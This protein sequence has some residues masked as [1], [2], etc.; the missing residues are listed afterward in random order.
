MNKFLTSALTFVILLCMAACTTQK[1]PDED[2]KSRVQLTDDIMQ[3]YQVD[4]DWWRIYN[5]KQLNQLVELA[6]KNNIDLAKSAIAVNKAL[7]QAN[8]LGENLV[9]T[10]SGGTRNAISQNI[11]DGGHSQPTHSGNLGVSYEVD[12]WQRLA[13]SVTAQQWEFAATI[14]DRESARLA[15]INSVVDAYYNLI[16]LHHAILVTE[17]SISNYE[18]IDELTS[19]K[20]QY[21][22]VDSLDP[23]QAKQAILNATSSLYDFQNQ[24]KVAEQT[25]RDLLNLK[26]NES[27]LI[28]YPDLLTLSLPEVDLNVPLSVIANRPDLRG[29]EYRLQS[30]FYD[31]SA[32]KKSW[33][34]TITL[35]G[36]IDS[37]S[38][39]VRKTFDM[40][41]ASGSLAIDLPFLQWNKIR[42][43]IKISKEDYEGVKLDLE[44]GITTALN[45]INTYYYNYAKTQDI[46]TNIQQKYNYDVQ[47]TQYY[48][49][50]YE[51]G[52]GELKDWLDA[53]NTET[54]SRISLLSSRH[55]L[56]QYENLIYKAIAGRYVTTDKA[57]R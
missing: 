45:E 29:A 9:P 17:Q 36:A 4:G 33:Y 15:L 35:A 38:N 46:L 5:D 23:A 48:N 53:L 11:K 27:L 40:P 13:D 43:N 47:I 32:V 21:G 49:I 39:K 3:R 22:K 34:P 20:Y 31:L 1:N 42:W 52:A 10:F 2:L 54:S 12:L 55:Q 51:Q 56:I 18:K 7:Y 14:Q 8:L 30:A 25:L 44:K 50:R 57:T 37:S 6:M 26:P 28:D 41:I 24:Q 16:Y 19:Y